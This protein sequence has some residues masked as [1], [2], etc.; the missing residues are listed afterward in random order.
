MRCVACNAT[1]M[2]L[3]TKRGDLESLCSRC[4]TFVVRDLQGKSLDDSSATVVHAD[5]QEL[6]IDPPE[7]Q[8][9]WGI[10]DR[11]HEEDYIG[12]DREDY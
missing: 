7:E 3:Y 9:D 8:E 6:G 4:R 10:L 12:F 11:N 5:P 1:M 2:V